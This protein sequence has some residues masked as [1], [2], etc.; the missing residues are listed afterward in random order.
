MALVNVNEAKAQ[1][2][3]DKIPE[4]HMPMMRATGC[5]LQAETLNLACDRHTKM[6]DELPTVDAIPIEWFKKQIDWH[7]ETLTYGAEVYQW[8]LNRWY[9][10][11][12]IWEK[13]NETN[14][15]R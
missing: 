13:E 7:S 14:R 2:I 12:E 5:G 1:I 10:D 8:V 4:N 6:L 11:K 15:C 9:E 3:E